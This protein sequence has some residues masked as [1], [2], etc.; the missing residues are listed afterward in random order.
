ME[1]ARRFVWT[2]HQCGEWGGGKCTL[3]CTYPLCRAIPALVRG[4]AFQQVHVHIGVATHQHLQHHAQG[5]SKLK[6]PK[7]TLRTHMAE[8]TKRPTGDTETPANARV[9]FLGFFV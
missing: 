5:Y 1:K 8:Q 6:H 3:R 9:L 7:D 2:I 4:L